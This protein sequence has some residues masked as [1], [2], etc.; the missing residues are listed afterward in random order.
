MSISVIMCLFFIVIFILLICL[1]NRHLV[2]LL[3]SIGISLIITL[4]F[5]FIFLINYSN[6][7]LNSFFYNL[8]AKFNINLNETILKS[9]INCNILIIVFT[10]SFIIIEIIVSKI[11][12]AKEITK[13]VN[14][15][16][17]FFKSF[18][19]LVNSFFSFCFLLIIFTNLSVVY[20]I[21]I[22]LFEPLFNLVLKGIMHI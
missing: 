14:G 22:G 8:M 2:G 7:N 1:T 10:L 5:Y 21:N 4:G 19:L 12:N 17:Y 16:S 20:K 15:K 13:I 3:I 18:L 9:F 11:I 6:D